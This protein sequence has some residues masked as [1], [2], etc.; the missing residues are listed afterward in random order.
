M[1][2]WELLLEKIIIKPNTFFISFMAVLFFIS[3]VLIVSYCFEMGSAVAWW[4]MPQTL[5]SPKVLVI[6]RKRWLHPIMTEKLFTG[7][8]RIN[9][10]TNCFERYGNDFGNISNML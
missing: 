8:L 2:E 9:Q 5:Y 1:T 10:P 4:L 7:T 3:Y 6:P